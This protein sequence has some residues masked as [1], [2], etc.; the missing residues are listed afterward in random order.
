[1]YVTDEKEC[2]KEIIREFTDSTGNYGGE[3]FSGNIREMI[4]LFY[5]IYICSKYF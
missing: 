1:M 5:N 3:T 2:E 4:K